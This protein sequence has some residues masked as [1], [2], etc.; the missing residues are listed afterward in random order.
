M[1]VPDHVTTNE[2][3][4]DYDSQNLVYEN[5]EFYDL[6]DADDYLNGNDDDNGLDWGIYEDDDY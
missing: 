5:E 4:I 2:D 1:V 3:D 6:F